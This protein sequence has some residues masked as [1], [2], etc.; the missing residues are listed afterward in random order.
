[1]TGPRNSVLGVEKDII[2]EKFTR[3]MPRRFEPA[4]GDLQFNGVLFDLADDG[5]CQKVELIN[6]WE[7]AI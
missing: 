3:Q 2:I 6:F 7:P 5:R 1:M 4:E